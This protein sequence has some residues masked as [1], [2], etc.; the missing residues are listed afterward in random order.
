MCVS[1][2]EDTPKRLERTVQRALARSDLVEIRF[3][4]LDPRHVPEAL[5]LTKRYMGRSVC[6]LRPK[7]EG[8]RFP[9]SEQERVSVLKLVAEY[10]PFLLD[11]EFE[12]LKK[13][14]RLV[15]YLRAAKADV[16]VSW[17]DFKKTPADT[18][19]RRRLGQMAKFSSNIKIVTTA[20]TAK[21]WARVMELYN[22]HGRSN[23]V[24]FCMG[25]SGRPSRI[26][27]LY[28]GSPYTYV[29]FGRPVAPGQFSLDEMQKITRV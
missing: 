6:T 13:N 27:C 17:H 5:H 3:D 1:V 2:A 10:C 22:R 28:L 7:S 15:E 9:G 12:T 4:F 19:L 8:G 25:E 24:A 23:L 14:C 26:L 21:D 20:K 18:V 29:S 11:V 16:L